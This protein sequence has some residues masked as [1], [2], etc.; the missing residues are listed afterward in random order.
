MS[1]VVFTVRAD[2]TAYESL[3]RR[4]LAIPHHRH[5]HIGGGRHVDVHPAIPGP[6]WTTAWSDVQEH[7]TRTEFAVAALDPTRET[8]ATTQERTTLETRYASRQTLD[9]SWDDEG[10]R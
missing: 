7:P 6:G 3:C 4:A 10:S 5:R 8:A 9:A 2:A 1:A